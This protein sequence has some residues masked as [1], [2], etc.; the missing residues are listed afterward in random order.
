M[1]VFERNQI[2]ITEKKKK[3]K[4]L[5]ED[6]QKSVS[7]SEAPWRETELSEGHKHPSWNVEENNKKKKN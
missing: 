2:Y 5:G 1:H 3:R 7:T 4:A 6:S